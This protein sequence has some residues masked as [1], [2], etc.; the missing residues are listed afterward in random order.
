MGPDDKENFAYVMATCVSIGIVFSII[1]HS[2]VNIKT[3]EK[4]HEEDQTETKQKS[5]NMVLHRMAVLD[6]I[7]LPQLYQVIFTSCPESFLRKN[8]PLF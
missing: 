1:F 8:A 5:E 2:C 4:M 6:W 3:D 7:K